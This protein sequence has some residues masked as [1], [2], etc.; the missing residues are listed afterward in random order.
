MITVLKVLKMMTKSSLRLED[1]DHQH[2]RLEDDDQQFLKA[3]R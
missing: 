1:A 2:L 3:G